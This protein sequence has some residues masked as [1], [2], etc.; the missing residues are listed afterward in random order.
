MEILSANNSTIWLN[1]P[2]FRLEAL[3]ILIMDEQFYQTV[4]RRESVYFMQI[5]T[6][7]VTL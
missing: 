5:A 7:N 3:V 4:V 1:L 6:E 2:T